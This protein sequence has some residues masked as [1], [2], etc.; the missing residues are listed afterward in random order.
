MLADSVEFAANEVNAREGTLNAKHEFD[1][2]AV[3][4][5][6]RQSGLSKAVLGMDPKRFPV[7]ADAA[8]QARVDAL[9]ARLVPAYQRA[10]PDS[11]PTK[12]HFRFQVVDQ[13]RL[14]DA[15]TLSNGIIL[16]PYQVIDRLENDDQLATVLADNIATALE[17]QDLR[18]TPAW[19]KLTAVDI[20]GAA[21]ALFVPGLGLATGFGGGAIATKM[22]RNEEEQSG[23]VSLV[24]LSDAGFRIAEAPKT[25]WLLASLKP[26][27]I[28]KIDMPYRAHYLY[29]TLASTW[30]PQGQSP[31]LHALAATR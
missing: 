27:D 29:A 15:L 28:S 21:G 7:H 24:L 30:Q 17:K 25:W 2:A 5:N 13:P 1:P 8:M 19:Q 26:K 31:A 9:G 20:A 11:E 14:H 16:V 18:M 6:D 10:M 23:R 3:T 22:L 12:I 4:D